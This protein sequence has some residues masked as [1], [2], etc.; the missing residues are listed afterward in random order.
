MRS[1][2]IS[3]V[4]AVTLVAAGG[5]AIGAAR[6]GKDVAH[7]QV[8]EAYSL[9][10]IWPSNAGPRPIGYV[11]EPGGLTAAADG[12]VYLADVARGMIHVWRGDQ[13][14]AVFGGQGSAAGQL[15][16]PHGL[17]MLGNDVL[18]A[19]TGNGRVQ[20]FTADGRFVAA[21]NG[22]GEPWGVSTTGDGLV[23]VTDRLGDRIYVLDQDGRRVGTLGGS[24]SAWGRLAGPLGIDAWPDG[25]FAVVDSG[26]R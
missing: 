6:S 26:R 9:S 11:R 15:D 1:R 5:A 19:D 14:V 24:G 18:A 16:H 10:G 22:L 25:H 20:R 13:F 3:L 21:W 23:L 4:V 12:T 2:G 7:A 8:P 17:C